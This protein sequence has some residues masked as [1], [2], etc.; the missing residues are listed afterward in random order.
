MLSFCHLRSWF[1]EL[2][3]STFESAG[4]LTNQDELGERNEGW[5]AGE[6]VLCGGLGDIVASL[7][8]YELDCVVN[9]NKWAAK[10]NSRRLP[11]STT[12]RACKVKEWRLLRSGEDVARLA[13]KKT[14]Q[15][16]NSD[17]TTTLFFIL[18]CG[19]RNQAKCGLSARACVLQTPTVKKGEKSDGTRQ[20]SVNRTSA[21]A[22]E[23]QPDMGIL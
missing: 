14:W 11:V 20:Y 22:I 15:I 23:P 5:E 17:R 7:A 4:R 16:W 13:C 21:E 3:A 10:R 2:D 8:D 12:K 6:T 18:N 9:K 19:R 1:S